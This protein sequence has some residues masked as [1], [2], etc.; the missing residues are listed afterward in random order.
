MPKDFTENSRNLS[1]KVQEIMDKLQN[2][3]L[4]SRE[5]YGALLQ[6]LAEKELEKQQ[7]RMRRSKD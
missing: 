6:L 7:R 4:L 5:E 2:T 3:V 1:A